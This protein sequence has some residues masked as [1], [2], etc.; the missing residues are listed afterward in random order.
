MPAACV[1]PKRLF[2]AYAQLRYGAYL[3]GLVLSSTDVQRYSAVCTCFGTP[4]VVVAVV[5]VVV[6]PLEG[7][8][9]LSDTLV[10]V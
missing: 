7:A 9:A 1:I 3:L 2:A 8:V 4:L 6:V 10:A 5:V